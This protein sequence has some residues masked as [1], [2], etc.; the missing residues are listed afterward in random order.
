MK[1]LLKILCL[2]AFFLLI[3]G[4]QARDERLEA[5]ET[6]IEQLEADSVEDYKW[7]SESIGQTDEA[8][9]KLI[10]IHGGYLP[11]APYHKVR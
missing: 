4:L 8:V 5:M 10:H 7:F 9:E 11:E 1:E 6:K 2:P 3:V